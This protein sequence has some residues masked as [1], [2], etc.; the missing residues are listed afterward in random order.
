[1]QILWVGATIGATLATALLARGATH[2]GDRRDW[3]TALIAV[4][5]ASS[6]PL[7]S[8][9]RFGQVSVFVAL[10]VIIDVLA[11]VPARYQ[12]IAT[13]V[14]AAVKLTPLAFVP[15]LW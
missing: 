3:Q 14:A 11:R 15:Y 4:V 12:G 5:L 1:V 2:P 8:T 13:G 7:S 9:I 6:G 10:L